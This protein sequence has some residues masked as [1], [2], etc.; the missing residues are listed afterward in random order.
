[1]KTFN[2]GNLAIEELLL[3]WVDALTDEV[4]EGE[5]YWNCEDMTGIAHYIVPLHCSRSYIYL[6]VKP[7]AEDDWSRFTVISIEFMEK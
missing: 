4:L 5:C 3:D 7:C 2:R 1:M 6:R